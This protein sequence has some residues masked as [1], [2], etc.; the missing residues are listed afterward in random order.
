MTKDW[1]VDPSGQ[2]GGSNDG[3]QPKPWKTVGFAIVQASAGDTIHLTPGATFTGQVSVLSGAGGTAGSPKIITSDPTNRAII[4]PG[5]T[6]DLALYIE[7]TAGL[8][9]EH[10]RFVGQ[11]IDTHSSDGV[12]CY[13][14]DNRYAVLQF[15]NCE[16]AHFGKSGLAIGSWS[17]PTHGFSDVMITNCSAHDN[18]TGGIVFYGEF[19]AAN[20]N[21]TVSHCKAY[22]NLGDP[23]APS[24]TG[25]GILIGGVTDGLVKYCSAYENGERCI[26]IGGPVGIWTYLS[27]RVTI[28]H[29]ESYSNRAVRCDGGGFD[30]DG[31]AQDCVIQYCYSHHNDGAGYLICQYDTAPAYNNNTIRYCISEHDGQ[32]RINN[33]HGAFDFYSSGSSGGLQNT[34][35]YNNTIFTSVAPAVHFLNTDGQSGTK[36][37]NNIFVATGGQALVQG[38]PS[39]LIAQF[40]NNCYWSSGGPFAVAG[41]ASLAAWRSSQNQELLGA[42]E[43]GWQMDP[44]LVSPG[45]GGTIGVATQL[46]SLA[47]YK[48]QP[49]SPLIDRALDL[50]ARFGVGAGAQDFYGSPLPQCRS[51]DVGAHESPDVDADGL[52]DAWE[53]AYFGSTTNSNGVS[54]SDGDNLSDRDE[55]EAGTDPT[56]TLSCFAITCFAIP[57]Q[58]TCVQYWPSSEGRR[59]AILGST[60]LMTGFNEDIAREITATPPINSYTSSVPGGGPFFYKVKIEQN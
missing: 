26:T 51:Y 59:Y 57:S 33:T 9:F 7:N 13:A 29:C 23:T 12:S 35:L 40:Q 49:T 58:S 5:T 18:R 46:H 55:F 34:R 11:G 44:R 15:N 14:T 6:T 25:N 19:A 1:Y 56:N 47:A 50:T 53:M 2:D 28:E 60:N 48:L 8:R 27:T 32:R 24:H 37:W 41:N 54:H 4:T 45:N 21:V 22:R 52:P 43:T 10:L 16:F 17:G 38:A 20:T 36:F 39:T 3:S 30:I 31:G 42:E